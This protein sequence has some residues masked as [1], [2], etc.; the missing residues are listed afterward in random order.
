VKENKLSKLL[1]SKDSHFSER[2]QE[3]AVI[4]KGQVI[5]GA[6]ER[7]EEGTLGRLHL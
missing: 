6:T 3:R 5:T 1:S 7:S 4:L 2:K